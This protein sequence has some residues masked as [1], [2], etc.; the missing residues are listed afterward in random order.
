MHSLLEVDAH[1]DVKVG[2]MGLGVVSKQLGVLKS[3][4][5]VVNRARSEPY[6]R[7]RKTCA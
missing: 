4:I 1:E 3:S 5:D 6:S 2:L 7:G